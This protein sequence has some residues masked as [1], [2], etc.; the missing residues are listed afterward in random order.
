M[1][2]SRDK[3]LPKRLTHGQGSLTGT[4]EAEFSSIPYH[5]RCFWQGTKTAQQSCL[6]VGKMLILLFKQQPHWFWILADKKHPLI[7]ASS[8]WNLRLLLVLSH[9][10]RLCLETVQVTLATQHNTARF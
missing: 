4:A 8:N 6:S 5:T 10:S 1:E 3:V 2:A 7:I 9:N